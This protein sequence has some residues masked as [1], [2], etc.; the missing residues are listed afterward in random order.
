MLAIVLRVWA[1][2]RAEIAGNLAVPGSIRPD[3]N[4]DA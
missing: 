4:A 1:G 2:E 3:S